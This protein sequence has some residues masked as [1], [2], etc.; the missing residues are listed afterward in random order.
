M[1]DRLLGETRPGMKRGSF[2]KTEMNLYPGSVSREMAPHCSLKSETQ[3]G[4]SKA[5][6]AVAC[7][8]VKHYIDLLSQCTM[9]QAVEYS[10]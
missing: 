6:I 10:Q 1:N 9:Q 8:L 2:M 7:C 4:Q 5:S 3:A